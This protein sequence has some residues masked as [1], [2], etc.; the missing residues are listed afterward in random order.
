MLGKEQNNPSSDDRS[1][2]LKPVHLSG[3]QARLGGGF[4]GP[5]LRDEGRKQAEEI[6]YLFCG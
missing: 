6:W 5:A 4:A 2:L 3:S 1:Q